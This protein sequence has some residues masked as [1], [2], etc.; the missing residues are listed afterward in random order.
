MICQDCRCYTS[1]Y[2]DGVCFEC[3]RQRQVDAL[4]HLDEVG[5]RFDWTPEE[6]VDEWKGPQ[7]MAEK[8]IVSALRA[9]ENCPFWFRLLG[10]IWLVF[11][12][13]G[14]ARFGAAVISLFTK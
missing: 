8:P 4:K 14:F 2:A 3:Y 11:G 9:F 6:D 7:P 5:E 10:S 1:E 13:L 12:I